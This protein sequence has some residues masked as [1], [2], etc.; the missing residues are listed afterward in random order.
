M[1]KYVAC[2]AALV[3][4]SAPALAQNK[5]WTQKEL[6]AARVRDLQSVLMV[7]ALQCRGSGHDVLSQF[8]EF[9]KAGRSAIVSQNDVLK[10]KFV[11]AQGA[12][13][14]N[15]AYDSFTTALANAHAGSTSQRAGFCAMAQALAAEATAAASGADSIGALELLAAR[16]AERPAGVGADCPGGK[17]RPVIA[18]TEGTTVTTTVTTSTTTSVFGLKSGK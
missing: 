2:I 9:V 14:G 3:G 11:K 16:V 7:G 17:P 6:T 8:N 1:I 4:L 15:R 13:E 12:K 5:C 10:A 18:S